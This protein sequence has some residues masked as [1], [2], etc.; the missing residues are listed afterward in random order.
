MPSCTMSPS[1]SCTSGLN[2]RGGRV[3]FSPYQ[4]MLVRGATPGSATGRRKISSVRTST[5]V[6]LPGRTTN[7]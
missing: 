5:I 3:E 4:N 1:E 2:C 7:S 6:A